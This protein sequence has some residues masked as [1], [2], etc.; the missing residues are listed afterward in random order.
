MTN[1]QEFSCT[2]TEEK[3][4]RGGPAVHW[5][6]GKGVALSSSQEATG[7]RA[8]AKAAKFSPLRSHNAAQPSRY[9]TA[10]RRRRRRG[11]QTGGVVVSERQNTSTKGEHLK[12]HF[13]LQ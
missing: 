8:K 3:K 2:L 1:A 6:I 13:Q 9:L 10:V 7:N 12:W 5:C 11:K 4:V